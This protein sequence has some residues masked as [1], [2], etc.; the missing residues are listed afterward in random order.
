MFGRSPSSVDAVMYSYLA[1]LLKAPFPNNSLQNY[2][3]S[4]DNLVKFVVRISQNYFPKVVKA[5]E[6]KLVNNPSE[7]SKTNN[8]AQAAGD[9]EEA[10]PHETRNKVRGVYFAEYFAGGEGG[11]TAGKNK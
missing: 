11:I 2:L 3:N 1:C 9:E 5:Y 6:E 8:T 4:C 7:Q 10:W